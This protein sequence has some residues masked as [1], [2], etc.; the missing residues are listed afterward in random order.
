MPGLTLRPI[1]ILAAVAA[2]ALPAAAGAATVLPD[3]SAATFIA[4][5]PVTNP[6]F[7]LLP[8]AT[9]EFRAE[10][11]EHGKTVVETTIRSVQFERR[12]IA[13]IDAVV[14]R[15]TSYSNGLIVE[16]T[17]DFYAQDTDG[18][19]WY[20]GEDVTNYLYDNKGN[21]LGTDSG[22]AW[23]TGVNGALPGFAMP[24]DL[25]LGFTYYQEF[26]PQDA[27][28]D[29]GQTFATDLT[30]DSIFGELTDVLQV[31]ETSEA[32]KKARGFKYYAA[33]I[34]L[35][36][37]DEGLDKKFRKDFSAYLVSYA[38][39]SSFAA[40]GFAAS[41]VTSSEVVPEPATWVLLIGGFAAVGTV[42]RRRRRGPAGPGP[43]EEALAPPDPRTNGH[44]T[45]HTWR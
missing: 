6:Y 33:G 14:V 17:F 1:A 20:L 41:S 13:G 27:A 15:D 22:S 28:L 8:G 12:E 40:S 18:N 45:A 23:R 38:I 26:A 7:P 30:L 35:V 5:A 19:V 43:Y 4:G 3:F 39:P 32:E 36:Q 24:A 11:V 42:L 16:D 44:V 31:F 29:I 2:L 21:L 34:G 37:E 10:F 25:T 9:S